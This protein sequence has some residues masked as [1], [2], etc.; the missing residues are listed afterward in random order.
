MSDFVF[1]QQLRLSGVSKS[2]R[3][4]MKHDVSWNDFAPRGHTLWL[5]AQ[6]AAK[7]RE[8]ISFSCFPAK[9]RE[10]CSRSLRIRCVSTDRLKRENET[11]GHRLLVTGC[12]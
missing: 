1:L 7:E 9:V 12:C 10:N 3:C 11:Q 8:T 2:N 5:G 4:D 6:R